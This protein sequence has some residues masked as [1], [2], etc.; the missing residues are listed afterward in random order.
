MKRNRGKKSVGALQELGLSA[1]AE[2]AYESLAEFGPQGISDIARRTSDFRVDTYG[3]IEELLHHGLAKAV[4]NGKRRLY[5]ASSPDLIFSILK[6][7]EEK[8]TDH[9]GDLLRVFDRQKDG[10]SIDTFAGKKGIMSMYEILI[11]GARRK[12]DLLRIESPSHY[13][14][15]K[16]YYP[17][18]YW[19]RVSSRQGGDI[20]R[21]VI[22]NQKT[23]SSRLRRINRTE[24]PVPEKHLPFSFDLTTVIIEDKVA[25]IDHQTEK[26]FLIRNPRFAAYM[27]SI[28]WMLYDRLEKTAR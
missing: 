15:M 9:V 18:I 17:K 21:H 12:A 3:H 24:K 26:A 10:M 11:K 8:I 5:E 28:F 14:L 27:A 23:I 6:K 4:A 7:K 19:Q 13:Q 25:Y 22:T 20:E 1:G 2:R 16:G